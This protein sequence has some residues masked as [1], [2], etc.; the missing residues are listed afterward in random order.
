MGKVFLAKSP[1]GA[2]IALKTVLFPENLDPRARW[3]TVER[4]QR[5]A[6]AA[7]SLVHPS[8]CQVLD[9]GA[10][11][12]TFFI[13][14]EYCDGQ[15][16]RQLIDASGPMELQRAVEIMLEVCEAL[17]YAHEQGVVH[18]D[19]KPD[20]IM[21]LRGE[22]VKLMD[23]GLASIGQES[24]LTQTGMT[25]G[26]FAY[27]SPEQ[28]RGEKLDARS[29]I[30]SLGVTFYEMLTGEQAFKGEGPGAIVN[31]ILSKDPEPP[32]GLPA[33]VSRTLAKCLRKRP[34]Y[35]FQSVSEIVDSLRGAPKSPGQPTVVLPTGAPAS[36]TRATGA[37][38]SSPRTPAPNL[39]PPARQESGSPGLGAGA[40]RCPKCHEPLTA[41]T[42]TCWR[43]GTPNPAMAQQKS[44]HESQ[45]AINSALR[46]YERK[47]KRGWFRRRK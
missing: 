10:D 12:D 40:Y 30:F 42:P 20:N 45:I 5:E 16:L 33:H 44:L 2:E 14:M 35:R 18:R 27:M 13:V 7:R 43:C 28:A 26:T 11:R 4:F 31:E 24:G 36:A 46:D 29:D 22:A 15:T 25:M 6:R 37:P 3:E 19:I 39:R 17:A 38:A 41:N 21:V 9:I 32:T 34:A 8:I 23:F 1:D 47:S